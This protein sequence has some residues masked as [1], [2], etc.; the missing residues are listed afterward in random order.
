MLFT[1][2]LYEVQGP[3]EELYS[4]ERIMLDVENLLPKP[5]GEL[6]DELLAG[7]PRLLRGPRICRRCLP[8][9]NGVH[10]QTEVKI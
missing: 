4:Q 10:R 6:F 3:N 2:G 8:R 9:G 5:A 7:H 1:D